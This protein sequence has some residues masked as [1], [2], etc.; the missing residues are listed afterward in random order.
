M[1]DGVRYIRL[2]HD[3]ADAG[4]P[5]F[6]ASWQ[7]AFQTEDIV[8][9]QQKVQQT[10]TS[11]A[12]LAA[13][14]LPGPLRVP[15]SG[16]HGDGR[17]QVAAAAHPLALCTAAVTHIPRIEQARD[18]GGVLEPVGDGS[19]FRHTVWSPLFVPHPRHGDLYFSSVLNRHAS[20]VTEQSNRTCA[21]RSC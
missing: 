4:S 7:G 1:A 10:T 20:W 11:E 19:R 18:G 17:W 8:Q 9:A 5:T 21:A 2:L 12:C 15:F 14:P 6:Y 16:C 13:A 3:R